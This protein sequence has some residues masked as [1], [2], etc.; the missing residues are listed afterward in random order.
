MICGRGRGGGVCFFHLENNLVFQIYQITNFLWHEC[1]A[2]L[3]PA[4][5]TQNVI[6]A[7]TSNNKPCDISPYNFPP[8]VSID[9]RGACM[10]SGGRCHANDIALSTS[11]HT[12][13]MYM[14]ALRGHYRVSPNRL[15]SIAYRPL[16]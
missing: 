3:L 8:S 11:Y 15:S 2:T 9:K 14:V 4:P 13:Q 16:T 5:T 7:K 6:E 10:G 1:S 12:Y